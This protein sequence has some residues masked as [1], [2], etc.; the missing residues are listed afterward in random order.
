N[1]CPWPGGRVLAP[2]YRGVAL[3]E[4]GREPVRRLNAPGRR[5]ELV[6]DVVGVLV[7]RPRPSLGLGA[8][9]EQARRHPLRLPIPLAAGWGV[10]RRN[11]G[12]DALRRHGAA[13]ALYPVD[14]INVARTG[15][16][17]SSA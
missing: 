15:I 3:T 2:Q 13:G 9:G 1:I 12:L 7:E 6:V 5:R 17:V 4:R 14:H 16:R 10:G 8:T 11:G